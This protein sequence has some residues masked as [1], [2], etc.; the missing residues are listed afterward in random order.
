MTLT[1]HRN[2]DKEV[3]RRRWNHQLSREIGLASLKLMEE[4]CSEPMDERCLKAMERHCLRPMREHCLKPQEEHRSQLHQL[5]ESGDE[6]DPQRR[7]E[8]M[9]RPSGP[10]SGDSCALR[11]IY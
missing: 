5:L 3:K 1:L 6:L 11:P 10:C 8:Q 7:S 2:Q 4:G 9:G